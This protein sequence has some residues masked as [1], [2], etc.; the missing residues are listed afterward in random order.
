MRNSKMNERGIILTVALLAAL[1]AP[2]AGAQEKV[3]EAEITFNEDGSAALSDYAVRQGYPHE[4]QERGKFTVALEAGG[5][6]VS[7]VKRAIVFML[8]TDPP[9]IRDTVQQTINLAYS[10]GVEYL[11]VEHEG[12][13]VLRE[14]IS[15]CN[16]DG[17]CAG[18][19]TPANCPQD[20]KTYAADGVCN[21]IRDG[22]CDPD[23]KPGADPDCHVRPPPKTSVST[24]KPSTTL[25]IVV[26]PEEPSKTKYI[27][28][29]LVVVALIA[30]A[31][32]L[33]GG[34]KPPV[35]GSP[36]GAPPATPPQ[37][38]TQPPKVAP[39]KPQPPAPP[40]GPPPSA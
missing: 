3:L 34:G 27:I 19:E 20:C 23:C 28:A 1:L 11:I 29:G 14:K 6:R 10:D 22:G 15:V 31:L 17:S 21:A 32:K 40:V 12:R 18:E 26:T 30:A 5:A 4:S 2:A 16:Q 8:M 35:G 39:L 13:E 9:I 25:P 37:P 33:R 24:L 36:P 38:P 7:E